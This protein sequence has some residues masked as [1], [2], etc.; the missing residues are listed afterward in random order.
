MPTQKA[1]PVHGIQVDLVAQQD[2]VANVFGFHF[3]GDGRQHRQDLGTDVFIGLF[4]FTFLGL[5]A[6]GA[7]R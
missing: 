3:G 2:V 4:R 5:R 6:V 7:A 1:Q